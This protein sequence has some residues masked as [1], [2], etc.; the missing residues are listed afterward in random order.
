MNVAV[1]TVR[2][3]AAPPYTGVVG[4]DKYG[5]LMR[6]AVAAKGVDV[7][8]LHRAGTPPPCPT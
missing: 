8:H 4:D 3:G 6:Q 7:S 2:L 5:G 1:Y